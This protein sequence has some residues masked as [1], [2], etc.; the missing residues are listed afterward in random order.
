MLD[1]TNFSLWGGGGGGGGGRA[2]TRIDKTVEFI[3][4][5]PLWGKQE[6]CIMLDLICLPIELFNQKSF[7]PQEK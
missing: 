7:M 2:E 5:L 4:V 3:T 6:F 1:L